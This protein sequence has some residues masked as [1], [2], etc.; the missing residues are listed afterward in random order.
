M[1]WQVCF[2]WSF[3]ASGLLI[4]ESLPPGIKL[5]LQQHCHQCHAG[6]DDALE[7]GVRL[8]I[9][10]LDWESAHTLD[11]WTT[12]HEVVESGDMPPE[13]AD[14]FPA[15]KQRKN[16]LEWLEAELVNHAPPGGTLPRRL[17]RVEYQN[18]IRDLFDYPEFE[19]PPSFPS[20]V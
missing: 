19:L 20:D 12:I 11:L 13:D 5:F 17:N 7:G 6:R 1:K 3:V 14:A 16:L 2:Y 18:T 15:A 10:S 9:N 8:D 4:G